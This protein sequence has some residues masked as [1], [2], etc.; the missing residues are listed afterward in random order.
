MVVDTLY[1]MDT[2]GSG[3][4]GVKRDFDGEDE[5][6]GVPGRDIYRMR[7]K[8]RARMTVDG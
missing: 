3:T 6:T 2:E 4:V 1:S 5:G 7:A 8:Q